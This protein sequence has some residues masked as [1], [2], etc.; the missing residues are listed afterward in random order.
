M[1]KPQDILIVSFL[2]NAIYC[3]PNYT[4]DVYGL[5]SG[6]PVIVTL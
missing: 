1:V 2:F 4:F 5:E 6:Y 3:F